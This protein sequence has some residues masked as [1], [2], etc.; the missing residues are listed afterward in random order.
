M[1]APSITYKFVIPNPVLSVPRVI[2]CRPVTLLPYTN[3]AKTLISTHCQQQHIIPCMMTHQFLHSTAK[4][5]QENKENVILRGAGAARVFE[6]N[7]DY[8]TIEV[9]LLPSQDCGAAGPTIAPC[10]VSRRHCIGSFSV[11]ER[12]RLTA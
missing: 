3:N 10:P 1:Q 6:V 4:V 5:L 11:G 7:H 12:D 8:Y 9:C 2:G